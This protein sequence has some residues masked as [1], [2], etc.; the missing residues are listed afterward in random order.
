MLWLQSFKIPQYSFDSFQSHKLSQQKSLAKQKERQNGEI[1][2][3]GINVEKTIPSLKSSHP[4]VT[5]WK[6]YLSVMLSL[7]ITS[8]CKIK[9][10]NTQTQ[11]TPLENSQED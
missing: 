1:P 5:V 3:P 7:E 10:T 8:A 4:G 9:H 6:I 11:K 2:H